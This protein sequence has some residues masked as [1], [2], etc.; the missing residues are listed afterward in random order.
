MLPAV[1]APSAS[2]ETIRDAYT[3]NFT[4]GRNNDYSGPRCMR[5]NRR[6]RV[7]S[8]SGKRIYRDLSKQRRSGG[9]AVGRM[10]SFFGCDLFRNCAISDRFHSRHS[11]NWRWLKFF[12][13]G[14]SHVAAY[15]YP[16]FVVRRRWR[17]FRVFEMGNRRG[18]G[19]RGNGSTHCPGPV[20]ARSI[21]NR[22][23]LI[24]DLLPAPSDRRRNHRMRRRRWPHSPAG[25]IVCQTELYCFAQEDIMDHD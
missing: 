5:S 7:G 4:P 6:R 23:N 8:V 18:L 12:R 24:F 25:G 9:L 17:L 21:K 15:C 13:P 14:D 1:A 3:A 10:Q 16:R 22:L 19:N 2:R 11:L 20:S